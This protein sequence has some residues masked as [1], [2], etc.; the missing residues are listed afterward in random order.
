[1]RIHAVQTGTVAIKAR[2]RHGRGR[3]GTVRLINTLLDKVWTG[4]LPIYAWVVEHPEG[5][6]VIDTG[7]TARTSEPGYFPPWHPYFRLGVRESVKPEEEIGP[8]LQALG[9]PPEEVR[10]VV[11]THLHMDHA[12]G[13]HHFPEAEI[14]VS[15]KEYELAS[16]FMGQVR[17]Y[18]PHRW[19]SW[20]APHL[21]DFEPR[22]V[23]PFPESVTLT[24]ASDV[25]LVPTEGHTGGH[26][27]VILQDEGVAC[28]F[29]GDTSYT[30]QLMLD[31]VVDGVAPDE[32]AAR[33]TL[34]RILRYVQ[35]TPTVYLPSH[36]PESGDRSANRNT[37]H[38]PADYRRQAAE[39]DRSGMPVM[40]T[41]MHKVNGG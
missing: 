12:G 7:E 4:P 38:H 16:G 11:L 27:S 10:W 39:V 41:R 17:G 3:S 19:P 1:M 20:F 31:Q 8:Q 26:I 36:D 5:V 37:T 40:L 24:E 32:H 23:G 22:P 2:Q 30:E 14:I 13:L 33:Q 15:R 35:E 9:I 29:A 18:L 34:A 21:I 28:F 25:H 6:I